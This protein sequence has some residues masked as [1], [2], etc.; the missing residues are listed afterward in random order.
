MHARLSSPALARAAALPASWKSGRTLACAVASHAGSS[1]A[2]ATASR[3]VGRGIS[4][5]HAPPPRIPSPSAA[6]RRSYACGCRGGKRTTTAYI[7]LGG[8]LGDRVAEIERACNEMDKRGIKVTR[9][10]SLWETEPMYVTDQDRFLN[11]VAEVCRIRLSRASRPW[12][13]WTCPC[14]GLCFSKSLG[15]VQSYSRVTTNYLPC[16][17]RSRQNLHQWPS[18]MSFNR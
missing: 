12:F 14:D 2:I 9:T 18:W 15:A 6:G 7:A 8:N 3:T 5:R 11:G 17:Y 16:I 10:S 4:L 13:T 1:R